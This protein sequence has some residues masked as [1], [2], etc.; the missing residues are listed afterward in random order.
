M[1]FLWEMIEADTFLIGS[2]VNVVVSVERKRENVK[3][4]N[5][6]NESVG[7]QIYEGEMMAREFS[8]MIFVR[9]VAAKAE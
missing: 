5:G 9:F 3:D 6:E 7:G 8:F 2:L 1:I 4:E